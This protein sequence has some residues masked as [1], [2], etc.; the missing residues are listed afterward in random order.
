MSNLDNVVEVVALAHHLGEEW[1]EY[2]IIGEGNVSARVD[3]ETFVV[4]ASGAN[5]RTMDASGLVH[6]RW[7]PLLD[8]LSGSP[9]D[10]DVARTLQEAKI[11]SSVSARPSMET[12]LHVV[13]LVEGGARF[14]GHAHPVAVNAILC[15]QNAEALTRHIYPDAITVC[16]PTPVFVP[17]HDPGVPL[18]RAVRDA[19]RKN[20]DA[21][22]EF[23]LV[24]YLQ[25]HGVFALGQTAKQVENVTAMAVKNAD[26]MARTFALGGPRYLTERD[27]A[28]IHTRPDEELR[29]KKFQGG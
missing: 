12:F 26:V 1:R 21:N 27:V 17:Y 8:L 19:L 11:D 6:L 5:M 20:V 23:P 7:K 28:R 4:K 14:V 29:R 3:D 22:G 24:I 13:A 18:A 10:A 25:N 2:V 16:G 15:S 9:T